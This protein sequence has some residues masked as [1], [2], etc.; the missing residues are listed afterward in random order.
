[1]SKGITDSAVQSLCGCY[2]KIHNLGSKVASWVSQSGFIACN[3]E[4]MGINHLQHLPLMM[5]FLNWESE[6]IPYSGD[7]TQSEY[8]TA[9][10]KTLIV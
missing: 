7:K 4:V 3:Q 2:N 1:M 9:E 5:Q 6:L 8:Y 10:Y